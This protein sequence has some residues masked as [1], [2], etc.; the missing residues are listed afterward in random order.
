MKKPRLAVS[1]HAVLRYLE[2][3]LEEDVEALRNAIARAV[4]AAEEHEGC[5]AVNV[6]G[7]RYLIRGDVVTTV[8]PAHRPRHLGRKRA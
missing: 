5:S 4:E 3:V 2:Q 6:G 8:V 1:D 7:F